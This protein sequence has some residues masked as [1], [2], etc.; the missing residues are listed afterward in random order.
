[1]GFGADTPLTVKLVKER[2]RKLAELYHPDH[3]G[4]DA[5]MRRINAAADALL[6]TFKK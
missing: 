4:S 6:A 5:A 3:G 2:R 1:M